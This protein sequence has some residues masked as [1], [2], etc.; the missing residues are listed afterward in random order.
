V[1]SRLAIALAAILFGFS[2]LIAGPQDQNQ[3]ADKTTAPAPSAKKN[4][5]KDQKKD[6][7]KEEPAEAKKG[8]MTADTFSGLKFRSLG[9]AAASGRVMAIAVNPKDKFEY[10]VGVAS[11]GVWKTVND[12]TTW[13]PVFEKEASY[14]IGWVALDPNDPAVVWV[15]TGESNSQRSVAYGDGIYRSDD[16]GKDWQNLGLKK[17]AHIGRVVVDPRDSKVVYVAAEGPLSGPGGDRGLYKTTDGGKN[18]KAALTISENTGVVDVALDPSN[19]D[20]IYAAAYQR[21][22]HVFTLIDG[23]PESAIYKS[24]DAGATW[25]KLKNGLP[26]VDMGRIGLAVSPADPNVLYATIEAADGK[27]G[28]FRSNDRGATWERKNEFDVGAMYYARVVCDP[29]NVD[30]IWVMN[31]QLRESLDGGK[32]LHKVAETNHHGDNH[33]IWIDPDDTKHWLLGSDGGMYETWDDAKSW[34]F[35]ANL[36][37]V[38]FYDVAVDNA[39]PFY[40]VCGGTQDNFSWCGPSRTRNVNGI[41]NSDWF[42]T[43]GGDGFRSVVDPVDPNTIYSESQYGVLVRHDKPTGQELV[44]QPQEGKGEPP[45]RW[46]WDS[47]VIISPHSHTRLYFAA[48]KLFRSDD[49]GDTWKAISGDLTRQIDRNKLPVMGKVWEPDAVAKNAS[50]S[51]YGNIV[52]LTE[53]P[54]KEG[55]IYVGTDDGLVQVTNDGGQTWTKYEKFVS[56]PDMTYVSRLAASQHDVN[57]VYAAFDNHKNEDFKPYLLKSTDA[58]KTWTSIAGN[59][60][61]NGTVLAFAEDAVNANLLFAGTEFGAFFTVDGGA[62]WVQLKGG[63]PTIAVRDMVLQAREGDLVI[64]T[65]G[66]GFYVLDDISALRETKAESLEQTAA[67]FPVKDAGLYIERHPLGEPKKGFQGDAF[68]T[69]ENPPYGAV[70]TA[71]LKEKLKTKKEKRQEAE[72]EAAKKNQTLPYPTNDELRAEAE[73]KKPEVYFMVYDESGT[74]IRRVEGSIE[75]GFQRAAWDLRYPVVALPKHEE[76][77]E[78]EDFPP[79]SAKGTLVLPGSYSV[80]CF[81]DV[82]GVVTELGAVQNF[83]V[84][85]DG[86]SSMNAGDLAAR[87]EFHRKVARLYRAVSGAMHTADEVE[88]RMKSMREALKDTP[89]AEKQLEAEADRIEKNTRAILRALSGDAEMQK[90]NEP[91]A[92]SINDRIEAIMEGER[93]SLA[94]PT[95]SHVEDYNIAAA[96]F[97][98]QLGKLHTLVE[99]DLAKLEKD[100]E[101]AGA[102]WTPG[103]VPEWSEK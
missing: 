73:E 51:F 72:K 82:E 95:Q 58:G 4:P 11:G 91:V 38:Q 7:K 42:V 103:R 14:S 18:W 35:K 62:H 92:S 50:T 85:T 53:S 13:T 49:R 20:V 8:G 16:G 67:T 56:L 32:T 69:A 89:A 12:G 74:A 65:F 76:E 70:F 66:R 83:K 100:M 44:L 3:D 29:K 19:P 31:V 68:F 96:E 88:D 36:P 78:E 101:A 10:Y 41:V 84:V 99:V 98:E 39:I 90:R 30:R 79:A 17:S 26:T 9:P 34:G 37:T 24:T 75:A 54:K 43:T 5:K 63:L 47:P 6:E 46:N 1:K 61:E 64:A 102:P 55:L 27:G 57:T 86:Q 59:L 77:E 22:R 94:K 2:S 33:A 48:N 40:N 80:K 93:F 21:R 28:I 71:Y 97:A 52:A 87:E 60:P 15:G 81:E 23:G 45:L 25:N